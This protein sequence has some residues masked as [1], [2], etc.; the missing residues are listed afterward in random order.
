M[1]PCFGLNI[2]N[3]LDIVKYFSYIM[4]G[5]WWITAQ[6]PEILKLGEF[7]ERSRDLF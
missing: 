7:P 2:Q 3:F 6:M 1:F 4:D 5:W